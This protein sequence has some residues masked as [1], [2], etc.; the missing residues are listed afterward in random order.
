MRLAFR[1][2]RRVALSTL[3]T[4]GAMLAGCG[5]LSGAGSYTGAPDSATIVASLIQPPTPTTINVN[6]ATTAQRLYHAAVSLPVAPQ[7]RA[8]PAIAGPRYEMTFHQNGRPDVT[9]V[10]DR[11]GCQD[12]T[13]AQT[14][15]RQA[16]EAFW[17]TLERI[18]FDYSPPIQASKLDILRFAPTGKPTIAAIASAP[19]AQAIYD[20]AR[21][22]PAQRKDQ[23]CPAFAG[24]RSELLFF[25]GDQ[26]VRITADESNCGSVTFPQTAD[27]RQPDAAFW[28][29]LAKTAGSVKIT[30]ARP[31][32]LQVK[33]EPIHADPSG[34]AAVADVQDKA[35]IARLYDVTL[36]LPPLT[37]QPA[38]ATPSKSL[39]GLAFELDGLSL[40]TAVTDQAGCAAATLD[41]QD[42]RATTA[43]FWP[44]V[45][46]TIH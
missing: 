25:A 13:L 15:V 2:P 32:R 29:L 37:G 22:L 19:A 39:Y 42:Q 9:F 27:K 26:R 14:D 12:V 18:V 35:L 46:Q 17:Q 31:D 3:L 20:A 23:V 6:D 5:A 41:N 16:D 44:L 30:E 8:C 34:V 10:A 11:G 43:E 45:R 21:A 28:Q 33:T 36:A 4:F 40:L 7:R 24:S 38:C 1:T